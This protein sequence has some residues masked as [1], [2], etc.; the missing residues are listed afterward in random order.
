VSRLSVHM[1][2][3]EAQHYLKVGELRGLLGRVDRMVLEA[4]YG[5]QDATRGKRRLTVRGIEKKTGLSG[6]AVI[7]AC[8]RL[9]GL[10]LLAEK[11]P[12]KGWKMPKRINK[13]SSLPRR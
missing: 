3:Q 5:G 12:P 6:M 13:E 9:S 10:G 4:V 8:Y 7:L 2:E 1:Q 11:A